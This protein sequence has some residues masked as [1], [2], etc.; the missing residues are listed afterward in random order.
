MHAQRISRLL[1][2][3]T[4]ALL[5]TVLLSACGQKGPLTLPQAEPEVAAPPPQKINEETESQG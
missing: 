1:R 2:L 3:L 4:G 5:A